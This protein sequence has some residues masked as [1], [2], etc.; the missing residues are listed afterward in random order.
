MP[1]PNHLLVVTHPVLATISHDD[2]KHAIPQSQRAE[3]WDHVEIAP[4]R[5]EIR[6]LYEIDW[7]TAAAT[8]EL[9]FA[10]HLE[11]KV[12]SHARLAYLGFAPIPLAFHLGYLVGRSIK[13]DVYQ[14]HHAREDWAWSPEESP[15][16][17]LAM[18]P[19]NLPDH[20]SS[21]AKPVVIRVST[22]HRIA[23]WETEEVVPAS[24]AVVDVAL[25]SPG[26]DALATPGALAEVVRVF[27]QALAGLKG[28]FPNLTAIHLFT[29]VP[30]GLAF[31]LGTQIN[32]T[33]YPEVVTYQ[34]GVMSTP[35]YQ[36]AIVLAGGRGVADS[37]TVLPKESSNM[38]R[39]N[40]AKH[41]LDQP[42]FPWSN[43]DA[44]AFYEIVQEAYNNVSAASMILQKSGVDMGSVHLDQSPRNLWKQALEVAASS[45]R[46]RALS[47]AV[48]S[49]SGV[50]A[51]HTPLC[52]LVGPSALEEPKR[53]EPIPWVGKELITGDQ[54]TF[55]EVS[56]L[57][58]GVRL[59]ASVVQLR[60]TN[61][62]NGSAMA[63]GFLIA[64]DTILT[65]HHALHDDDDAPVKQVAIWFNYELDAAGRSLD[66]D[67]Y[68]GDVASIVGEKK[69]DWAIVRS[70][71][72]FKKEYPIFN[73]RPSK[74]VSVGD[75][76][77]IV[78]HPEGKPK[79]IGLV[80]NQVVEVTSDHVQY[81]T[82]TL[83]GSSGSPVCNEFWDVVALHHYGVEGD[84]EKGTLC[85]NQGIHVNRV[86][87][88]LISRRILSDP[89]ATA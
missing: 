86:R 81:L 14:R 36:A 30:A 3:G 45:G 13:I 48:L 7:A 75:F 28:L 50:A 71:T 17:H 84:V 64:P 41:F 57:R 9:L 77:Y 39:S 42:K 10:E 6:K 40:A 79:K 2:I 19:L 37:A 24:L 27:N 78:Q 70:K 53:V 87:E 20:G 89:D 63:T 46:L 66:V 74:P 16:A 29:A 61:R 21:D 22:S 83:R 31:R 23:P 59:A 11:A 56:F 26:E 60:T 15:P 49:D 52:R 12:A 69:H 32:P 80:H 62:R 73:L 8:Q 4:Q 34:Y 55:L 33:I 18:K 51:H 85:K 88:G 44:Q 67:P 82:D 38:N 43:P 68:E 47:E 72:P 65:N 1:D 76:V 25:V 5:T 54:P 58:S 35:R